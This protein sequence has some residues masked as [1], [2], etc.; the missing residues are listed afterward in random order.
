MKKIKM[1]EIW[2]L[3]GGYNR[4]LDDLYR[5]HP[6]K[7][8]FLLR[9]PNAK[10]KCFYLKYDGVRITDYMTAEE[11]EKLNYSYRLAILFKGFV[12]VESSKEEG[13]VDKSLPIVS[14]KIVKGD[15]ENRVIVRNTQD[16]EY[17]VFSYY[18][19]EIS[20]TESEFIGLTGDEAI[21]LYHRKDVAYLRS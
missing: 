15:Y 18:P 5:P 21:R 14:A 16:Q 20:F 3:E 19:D 1:T 12:E 11:V 8:G 6:E 10:R 4:E 7:K 17:E 13:Y 9:N 2:K